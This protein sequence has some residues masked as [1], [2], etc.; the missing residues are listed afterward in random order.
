MVKQAQQNYSFIGTE[1]TTDSE[2]MANSLLATL[3]F[4]RWPID[5]ASYLQGSI[6]LVI[7]WSGNALMSPGK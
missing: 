7:E 4:P 2:E 6:I 1:H 3:R 5:L